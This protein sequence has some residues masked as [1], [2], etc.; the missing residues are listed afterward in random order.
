MEAI[1]AHLKLPIDVQFVIITGDWF[2]V[3][4]VERLRYLDRRA[5]LIYV[6]KLNIDQIRRQISQLI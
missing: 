1:D 4:C 2:G 6:Y 5:H 3:E